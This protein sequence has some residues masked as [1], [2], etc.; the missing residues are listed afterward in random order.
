VRIAAGV[1][2]DLSGR[3]VRVIGPQR[4][5]RRRQRRLPGSGGCPTIDTAQSTPK[6]ANNFAGL[7]T[8]LQNSRRMTGADAAIPASGLGTIRRR[9]FEG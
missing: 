3:I 6:G 2:T 1:G 8:S 9:I 5:L 7:G 4:E